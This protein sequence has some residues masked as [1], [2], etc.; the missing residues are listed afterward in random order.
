M[1]SE[2][3]H[4]LTES[5]PYYVLTFFLLFRTDVEKLEANQMIIEV[6]QGVAY[7]QFEKKLNIRSHIQY[8][9]TLWPKKWSLRKGMTGYLSR[10][11]LLRWP[12]NIQLN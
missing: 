6:D 7:V 4:V 10:N 9:A 5:V 12:T 2:C 1:I 11:I 8:I 3:A